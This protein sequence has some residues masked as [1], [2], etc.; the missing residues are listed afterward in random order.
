MKE[1]IV[2]PV[3]AVKDPVGVGIKRALI[4]FKRDEE[5][6][7]RVVVT[8]LNF[9]IA[10]GHGR[11]ERDRRVLVGSCRGYTG[12]KKGIFNGLYVNL[13]LRNIS[14]KQKK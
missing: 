11:K 7:M 10:C 1:A 12:H 5:L 13:I 9:A 14:Q 4:A 6:M 2:S 8:M 3:N